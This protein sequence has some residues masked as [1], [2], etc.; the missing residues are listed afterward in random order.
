MGPGTRAPRVPELHCPPPARRNY[1]LPFA[2]L[3]R[4][5]ILDLRRLARLGWMIRAAA[6]WSSFLTVVR[7]SVSRL[8]GIAGL[9]QLKDLA[10]SSLQFRLRRPIP[11][12]ADKALT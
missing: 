3:S 1:F 7:N 10:N 8:L 5:E 2:A 12:T 6:A 4:T 9:R 11:G